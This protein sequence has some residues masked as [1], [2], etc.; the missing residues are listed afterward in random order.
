FATGLPATG[1]LTLQCCGQCQQVNYPARE[2]CGNCLADEL[3]WRPVAASGTV[4]SLVQLHY[5][6]EPAFAEHLPRALASVRLDCGPVVLA[7]LQPGPGSGD[8]VT[9]RVIRDRDGNYMLAA[10]GTDNS[11]RQAADRWLASIDFEE[12]PA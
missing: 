2:L 8:P 6:L 4:Q 3:Q 10:L 1:T 11:S 5:S 7:H 9:I 12:V